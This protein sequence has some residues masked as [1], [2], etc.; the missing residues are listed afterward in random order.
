[1]T[2]LRRAW[3]SGEVHAE[4]ARFRGTG[5][6]AVDVR[7]CVPSYVWVG[8]GYLTAPAMTPETNCRW[9][10]KNTASGITIDTNAPGASTSMLLPN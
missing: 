9:K 2:G 8:G 3:H 5:P 6:L 1:M 10:A 7:P 4:A